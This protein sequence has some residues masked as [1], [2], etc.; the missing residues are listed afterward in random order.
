MRFGSLA[1]PLLALAC[2]AA[3]AG[4]ASHVAP[5]AVLFENVRVFD[6]QGTALSGPAH[7]L[8]RGTTIEKISAAPL[9]KSATAGALVIQ[10]GGRDPDARPHRRPLARRHGV[11][12]PRTR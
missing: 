9:A 12:A 7:V 4:P 3:G 2:A 10:G 5:G 6:G 1:W 8:V 11:G